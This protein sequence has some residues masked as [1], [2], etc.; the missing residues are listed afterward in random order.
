MGVVVID[1]KALG[2]GGE[3]VGGDR[4]VLGEEAFVRGDVEEGGAEGRFG[5]RRECGGM[6]VGVIRV[7]AK[8]GRRG[9][10]G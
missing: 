3:H 4:E 2:G 8:E 5:A 10:S 7:A 9:D 1:F 6:E